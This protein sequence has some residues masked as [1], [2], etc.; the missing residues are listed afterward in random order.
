MILRC[1]LQS[2]VGL[3]KES[4]VVRLGEASIIIPYPPGVT[5]KSGKLC[6]DLEIEG[7]PN[8]AN[9]GKTPVK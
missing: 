3:E 9:S 4:I 7:S 5:V 1:I 8:N 6:L 2:A